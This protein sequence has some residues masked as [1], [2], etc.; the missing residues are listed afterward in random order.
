M[1]SRKKILRATIFFSRIF[2]QMISE[3]FNFDNLSQ[4]Q[5]L[6]EVIRINPI[7]MESLRKIKL[8]NV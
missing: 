3:F 7:G 1:N 4:K 8:L 5:H 6:V 2:R